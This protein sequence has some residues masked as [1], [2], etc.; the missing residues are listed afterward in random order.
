MATILSI[1][2]LALSPRFPKLVAWLY[3]APRGHASRLLGGT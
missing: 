2:G 3:E 1:S